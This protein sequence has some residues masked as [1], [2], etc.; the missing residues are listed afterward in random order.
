M[1]CGASG[2]LM[3]LKLVSWLSLVASLMALAA[4]ATSYAGT[5]VA[6]KLSMALGG[7][8][9]DG[10]SRAGGVGHGKVD[11]EVVRRPGRSD[12]FR[13]QVALSSVAALS[14]QRIDR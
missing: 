6:E 9:G 5:G 14:T 10:M 13:R 12:V 4:P 11:T 2:V 8:M 7:S 1:G 3:R